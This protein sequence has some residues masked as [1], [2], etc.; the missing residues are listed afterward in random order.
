ML[1]AGADLT[2]GPRLV[3]GG[4]SRSK[5]DRTCAACCSR[6]AAAT[7]VGWRISCVHGAGMHA[8]HLGACVV[9]RGARLWCACRAG[10]G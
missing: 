2:L 6:R 8:Q 4:G 5:R 3:L 7:K 10:G 1:C 9:A